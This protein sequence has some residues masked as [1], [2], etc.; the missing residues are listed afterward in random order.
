M[1]QRVVTIDLSQYLTHR[2]VAIVPVR[3]RDHV[4]IPPTLAGGLFFVVL[5]DL[6]EG[7]HTNQ[8]YAFDHPPAP[9]WNRVL[10]EEGLPLLEIWGHERPAPDAPEPGPEEPPLYPA[11]IRAI[12][13]DMIQHMEQSARIDE[14]RWICSAAPPGEEPRVIMDALVTTARNVLNQPAHGVY[15]TM[16]EHPSWLAQAVMQASDFTGQHRRMGGNEDPPGWQYTPPG[17]GNGNGNGNGP[18]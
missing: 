3:Y 5:A 15:D 14:A 11:G 16:E 6:P 7:A 2:T 12:T 4:G 13:V 10:T 9:G 17:F 18:P 8:G 1:A